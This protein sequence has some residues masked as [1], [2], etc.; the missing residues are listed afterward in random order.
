MSLS[1]G[2]NNSSEIFEQSLPFEGLDDDDDLLTPLPIIP[3][4]AKPV[5]K[6]SSLKEIQL[7]LGG[8]YSFID[9]VLPSQLV[10]I[11]PNDKF[12][13][14]YF[15]ALHSMVVAK[16]PSWPEWTPNHLGARIPLRHSKLRVDRWRH[17]LVG[18]GNIEICQYVEFGFPLGLSTDPQAS[19][20]STNRNHGS[21]YQFYTFWDKF[22]VSGVQNTD[23]VGPFSQAPFSQIHISPLM[24]AVKKP[25][26]RRCV[27][28]ASFGD[29]SLN[30]NTPADYYMGQ[31]I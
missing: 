31:P 28:D 1:A 26:S 29:H 7:H 14:T 19:L 8:G 27:F 9:R 15:T 16:G 18:Y 12:S 20:V 23:V 6:T 21:S 10:E 17:H 13:M 22:T 11:E 4:P 24:T 3:E 25:D 2:R 30:N 5:L